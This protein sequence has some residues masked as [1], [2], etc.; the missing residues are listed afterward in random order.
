MKFASIQLS[1]TLIYAVDSPASKLANEVG[2]KWNQ[3][4]EYFPI[5][6]EWFINPLYLP[7]HIVNDNVIYTVVEKTGNH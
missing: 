6:H 5:F 4:E 3:K 2:R 1:S 7:P